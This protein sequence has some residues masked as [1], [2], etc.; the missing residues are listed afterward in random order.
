MNATTY[1]QDWLSNAIPYK[2]GRPEKC[3]RYGA[4]HGPAFDGQCPKSLF[5][6]SNVIGCD[7]YVFKTDE[8]RI[9]REVMNQ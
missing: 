9:M 2:N 6:E 1:D 4:L 8:Y 5:N 7:E 3:L